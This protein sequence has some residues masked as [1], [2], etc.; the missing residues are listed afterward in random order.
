MTLFG[1]A[2]LQSKEVEEENQWFHDMSWTTRIQGFLL[3]LALG[4]VASTLSWVALAGGAYTKYAALSTLANIMSLF[5][6]TLLMGP[7]RQC[8]AMWDPSRQ[9]ATGA[10]LGAIV[11][12]LVAAFMLHSPVLCALCSTVQYLALI[13]YSLSYVPYGHEMALSC[14]GGCRRVILSM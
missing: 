9:Q 12:T 10:Y 5:S 4:F 14:L 3:F 1:W 6:T 2:E 8:K 11:L 7:R 13:W